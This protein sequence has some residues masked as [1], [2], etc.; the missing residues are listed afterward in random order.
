MSE[1]NLATV[2]VSVDLHATAP[3]EAGW[4]SW[5]PAAALL[6][7]LALYLVMRLLEQGGL[8][9]DDAEMVYLA[10]D[11]RLGYGTQPPLYVW[12]QWLAFRWFGQNRFAL[13]LVKELALAL[14]YLAVAGAARTLV[15]RQGAIAA[16]AALLLFPQ[17]AWE[18][19]RIQ[20]HSVLATALAASALWSYAGLLGKP[21]RLR[22][23]G[24][25]LVCG[26]G[27]LAKYNVGIFLAGIVGASWM[28]PDHRRRLW[29]PDA[30]IVPAVATIVLLP[31]LS[32]VVR[33]PDAAFAA[34]LHKMQDG[35]SH[36]SYGLNLITGAVE[37]LST[38]ASFVAVPCIVFA[39]VCWPMRKRLAIDARAPASRFMLSLYG[40]CLL[41]LA[42]LVL[43]GRVGLIK[44]RWMMPILFGL[45]LTALVVLPGLR[46][47]RACR[48]IV[49]V[50][51]VV[52]LLALA[53][54]AARTWLGP[55]WGRVV[56]ANYPYASL[57]EALVRMQVRGA[58]ATTVI[59]TDDVMLAGN[60]R[61]D[62][63]GLRTLLVDDVVRA[64]FKL[65]GQAILVTQ[66]SDP[67]ALASAVR[68]V[69]PALRSFGASDLTLP[70]RLGAHGTMTFTVQRIEAGGAGATTGRVPQ[71]NAPAAPRR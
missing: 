8:E 53:A 51:A 52:A 57:A 10:Q 67:R 15:G 30:W 12:L 25:G 69:Y 36:L 40:I 58:P 35:T 38:M 32:W 60:L 23:A 11:M 6:A 17:I 31:H 55:A 56:A 33:H 24:F 9:R 39:A 34:T 65:R 16:S 13:V 62:C 61:F 54:L 45:P 49:R 19:L 41:L 37:L 70:L 26:L 46:T 18:A 22:Y 27:L 66:W 4:A 29:R 5:R 44:E 42:A 14:L 71:T 68:A 20:T 3:L 21:G 43:S 28:V 47:P 64:P 59:V 7:Y 48:A 50:A 1:E 2:P 63:P